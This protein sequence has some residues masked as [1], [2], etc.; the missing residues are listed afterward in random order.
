MP[1]RIVVV[2]GGAA[3]IGAAGSARQSDPQAAVTVYTEFEDAAYSPCGI[4]YVHG[5]EIPDFQ[6][7]FLQEKA[8]YREAGIDIHYETRVTALDLDGRTVQVEGAGSV[9]FDRLVVAT[10][11]DYADPGVPGTEL[12]GLYYV[13]NIRRAMEW[14][15]V[16]DAAKVAGVV[17]A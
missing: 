10:G 15:K 6:R 11:F 13:K 5:R 1:P 17:D 12:G 14:D 16:L 9:P 2:G 3:G 7:L 8:A 4:P